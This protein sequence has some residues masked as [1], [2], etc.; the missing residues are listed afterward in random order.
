MR[1]GYVIRGYLRFLGFRSNIYVFSRAKRIR[2]HSLFLSKASLPL[3]ELA[4][5]KPV[6][7]SRMEP[8]INVLILAT[9][10]LSNIVINI[11]FSKLTLV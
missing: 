8:S 5:V 11:V 3:V 9:L 2:Q 7:K 1:G 6:I 4:I 10:M